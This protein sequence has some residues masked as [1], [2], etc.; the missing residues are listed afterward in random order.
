MRTW[1][2]SAGAVIAGFMV[3]AVTS[4]AADAWMRTLDIFPSSL[5]AMS[6]ALFAWALAYRTVF[7]VIGG[8]VTAR[9]APNR[10]IRHASILGGIG[11]VAGLAGVVAY[12][13]MG[14][15]E[16]G[17]A[18]YAIAIAVEAFPCVLLGAKLA[19]SPPSIVRSA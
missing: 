9:L 19:P 1:L 13:A 7:T 14:A 12:Y 10:P 2:L 17:P 8:Y 11:C 5:R 18:W 15:G 6:G 4:V 16:L 3:T